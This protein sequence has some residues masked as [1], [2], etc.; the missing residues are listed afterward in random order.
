MQDFPAATMPNEAT[1]IQAAAQIAGTGDFGPEEEYLPGLRQMLA[2]IEQDMRPN[3]TAVRILSGQITQLLVNRAFSV[4]TLRRHPEIRDIPITRPII[5]TGFQRSGTTM[6]HRMLGAAPE[7]RG[8]ALWELMAPVDP[9]GSDS[10]AVRARM[11]AP[12]ERF[13]QR[14]TEMVPDFH[15]LIHPVGTHLLEEEEWLLRSTFRTPTLAAFNYLPSYLDWLQRE[16]MMPSYRHL[17]TQ[18][19]LAL[20]RIPGAHLILKAPVHLFA[21]DALAAVFPDALIVHLFRDMRETVASSCSIMQALHSVAGRQPDDIA[22]Q[23]AVRWMKALTDRAIE[24]HQRPHSLEIMEIHYLD[25]VRDPVAMAR[26]IQG[27]AGRPV[28][29]AGEEAMRAWLAANPS[30]KKHRYSLEQ[31]HLNPET[32]DRTFQRYSERFAPRSG[33]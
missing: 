22:G 7:N 30:H 29:K 31:Y 17:R 20:W 13:V 5:I 4:E 9:P 24:F 19:Q 16:D 32:V 25:L 11:V 3:E 1:L 8:L 21:L 27:R 15:Y 10:T 2:S 18:L 6:L 14:L 12:A 26:E 33:R 23:Y 28:D